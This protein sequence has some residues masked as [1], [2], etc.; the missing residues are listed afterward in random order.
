MT[1]SPDTAR[2]YFSAWLQADAALITVVAIL[3]VTKLQSYENTIEQSRNQLVDYGQ[4]DY[5]DLEDFENKNRI[6][7]EV[8]IKK[9]GDSDTEHIAKRFKLWL[10]ALDGIM[11]SKKMVIPFMSLTGVSLFFS[12]F[13]LMFVD[14]F[15]HNQTDYTQYVLCT[16]IIQGILQFG[17][18][19]VLL[20]C[21]RKLL[22]IN[23]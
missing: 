5:K 6:S 18:V 19:G 12:A 4:L 1:I 20:D 11:K 8:I 10:W 14:L 22:H 2:Y 3:V 17:V 21:T 9:Y 23:N 15:S 16:M 7:R 13:F